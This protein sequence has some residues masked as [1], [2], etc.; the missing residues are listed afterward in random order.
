MVI[1]FVGVIVL[2]GVMVCVAVGVIVFVGVNVLVG[3]I[4]I[5]FVGVM[6]GTT[7]TAISAPSLNASLNK[8]NPVFS[9]NLNVR[10]LYEIHCPA[11]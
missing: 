11:G 5:V 6:V 9:C 10:P 1:V 8:V 7:G 4:V 3:V 2:V